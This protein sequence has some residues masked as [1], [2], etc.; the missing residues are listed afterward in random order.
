MSFILSTSSFA[1]GRH[2]PMY[3]GVLDIGTFV[4]QIRRA[5][6]L[7]WRSTVQPSVSSELPITP[8]PTTTPT[9][10]V[11]GRIIQTSPG[12]GT[13]AR[14]SGALPRSLPLLGTSRV[15][16]GQLVA[17]SN[18]PSTSSRP[19][20]KVEPAS[21]PTKSNE[22]TYTIQPEDSQNFTLPNSQVLGYAEYGSQSRSAKVVYAF[23]GMPGSRLGH[24]HFHQ[25]GIRHNVKFIC[26][27]RLGYGL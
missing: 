26:P 4:R 12:T 7:P 20:L 16:L 25:W 6:K 11:Q 27:E 24:R 8:H 21:K 22:L 14:L 18:I 23:H 9:Q 15:A 3:V 1:V 5:S 10:N 19:G 2:V 17:Q 13:K